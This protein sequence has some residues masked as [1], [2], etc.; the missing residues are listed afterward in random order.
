M[1]RERLTTPPAETPL[2]AEKVL[3]AD[4]PQAS[5]EPQPAAPAPPPYSYSPPPPAAARPARSMR[6]LI[7]VVVAVIVVI[8]AV[9]G[10]AVAG[11]AYSQSRLNSARNEYNSVVDHQNKLTDA[12]NS[13]GNK[14]TGTNVVNAPSADIKS[15]QALVT[16]LISQSQD[17][18][19]QI[20]T[21][22]A[23]LDKADA[24]LKANSWL[25]VI[26]KS[27]IDKSTTRIGHL[28]KALADAKTITADYVQI[29]NFYA[30][31]LD[32]AADFDTVGNTA[33][34]TDITAM[35]A[36]IQK[37]K[38][39]VAKAISLD[40]APGLPPELDTFLKN[41]QAFANDVSNLLN[42]SASGDSAAYDAALSAGNADIAKLDAF[43]F[44]KMGNEI[45]AFYK[46]MI[47]DY[48]SEVGKAN[49]T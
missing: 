36:A 34:S 25:T 35:G 29:G 49:A 11:Y 45:D 16:Q 14:L 28:S 20:Q 18:Q 17:A 24:D 19:G 32:M 38:T 7:A 8:V 40:K 44:T 23:M 3:P 5:T 30:A 33:G 1:D 43:D 2:P 47:D 27:E 26:S 31:F 12:V 46:P 42:A 6:P 4:E 39:D 21:D 37:L 48:N 13:L 10:Y 9:I 41:T 15:D 22:Q